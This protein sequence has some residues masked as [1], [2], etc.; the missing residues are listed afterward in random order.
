MI[1]KMVQTAKQAVKA[2]VVRPRT[3]LASLGVCAEPLGIV[4]PLL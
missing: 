3:T 4:S 2:N 1:A